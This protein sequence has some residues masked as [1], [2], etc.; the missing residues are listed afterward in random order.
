ML[1]SL[2]I[3]LAAC[4]GMPRFPD[5]QPDHGQIVVHLEGEPREGTGGPTRRAE[6]S[7]YDIRQVSVEQGAQ[8]ERVNYR[9]IEDVVVV[10]R[11][12]DGD[13][14]HPLPWGGSGFFTGDYRVDIKAGPDGFDRAQYV[15]D[16]YP[17][18]S[19]I[20]HV[21]N[22]RR[23]GLDLYFIAEDGAVLELH[24]PAGS[25]EDIALEAGI[26]QVECDQD[27]RLSATVHAL[28]QAAGWIGSSRQWP[29]FEHLPPGQYELTVHPPRLPVWKGT[30]DVQA[31]ARSEVH[32][33]L[34]VNHMPRL[35]RE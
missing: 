29:F 32:V 3:L 24:V 15:A 8:F 7:G 28:H 10:L 17:F 6:I 34:S 1:P 16:G 30:V 9:A 14:N 31:G 26:Y 19:Q 12:A 22:T 35:D 21:I 33:A 13:R 2:A 25:A 4:G 20:F 11:R 18:G 27:E 5:P 23:D